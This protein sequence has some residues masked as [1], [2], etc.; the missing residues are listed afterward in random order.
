MM[1][2]QDVTLDVA[3]VEIRCSGGHNRDF[4]AEYLG[5]RY[6]STLLLRG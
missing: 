6:V 4:V 5:G 2:A 1:Y 3:K